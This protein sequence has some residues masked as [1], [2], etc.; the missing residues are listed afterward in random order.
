MERVTNMWKT[1]VICVYM[2]IMSGYDYKRKCV[3]KFLLVI[4]GAGTGIMAI[5]AMLVGQTSYIGLFLGAFP[6]LFLI[7]VAWLS[8]KAGYADGIVLLFLGVIYGYKE[9]VVLLCGS[10]L[11]LSMI[12]VILLLL[13]KVHKNTK[14]PYL[15]GLTIAFIVRAACFS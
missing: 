5:Y 3:P 2:L 6:G 14:L 8:K 11:L 15:P 13:Y 9:G 10:M 12:S 4:G 1:A 7:F